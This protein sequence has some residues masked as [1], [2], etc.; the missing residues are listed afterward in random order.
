MDLFQRKAPHFYVP[1]LTRS[2]S[3]LYDAVSTVLTGAGLH[4]LDTGKK[5]H[6]R[7][8]LFIDMNVLRLKGTSQIVKQLP[9]YSACLFRYYS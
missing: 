3:F 9:S 2:V 8:S 5:R 4:H 1:N 7:L 6:Q